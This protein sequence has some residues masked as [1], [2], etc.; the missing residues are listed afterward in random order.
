MLYQL[1][2]E[3]IVCEETIAY[4]RS[5]RGTQRDSNRALAPWWD[6]LHI[7]DANTPLEYLHGI[8]KVAK[9]YH[10]AFSKHSLD[11]G[12]TNLVQHRINTGDHLPI[13]EKHRPIPPANYQQVKKLLKEMKDSNVIQESQSP[14]A[15][16]IVLVKKKDGNIRFCVDYRKINT[17]THKDAYPL[18]RIEESIAALGSAAYFSTLDLTSGYWQVPMAPED[19]EKTA[20]TTPMGLFEFTSMPFGLCN[21]PATFQRLMERCLGHLNFQSV[22]LYLDDVIV[23]SRTYEDHV[24]HLAEVFQVLIDHGLK[25]KPSKCH[26]LKPQVNYLG[27]VVSA[28]GIQPDPE[29]ISAVEHWDTPKTVKE[30]RSF[31]GFAGYYRRFIPHFAQVA[32]PLNELLR[33]CPRESY[34]RRLPV[35]W[36]ERQEIA[37]Q[38]LKR[39]LTTPPILAYPDYNLPFRLYTDASFQGLGAVLSQVQDGQERVV[40]YASRSLRGAEKNDNNYSSFKLELLALVWAVTEKFKDYLAATPVTIYTDNNPLA[41]LNTARLGALE[42]RWAS[43]LANFQFEIKYRSGKANVNADLLSRLPKGE[44]APEDSDWEDVEMP[45][46]YQRFATQSAIDAARPET[47]SPPPRAP[48]DLARWQTIQEESRILGEIYDYLSTGRVPMRIKRPYPDVELRRL[49]RQRK[50]LF[51]QKGL[52]LRNSLDPVSGERCHQILIPRRDA[53]MVL[54]AYHDRSG[55]FGVHKTEATIRQ[56]FYWIGMRADIE[57]WCAECP[58]CNISKAGGREVRAPL[59]PITSHRPNQ[60]VALDHVKLAPTRC[61]YTYALTMV[62][63]YSKWVVVVPVRD[64][65]AKTTALT[66]YKE[67]VKHYGCPESLLTDRGPAFESQLFQ[68]LCAYHECKKLRTTAYHPQGNGLC[69]KVNQVFIN[70]LRTASVTKRVEWPHL[71]DELVEIYNN[72][73]HCSTGYSPFYLMFGRQGQLPQ[74]RALGVQAPDTFNP[75]P[76]TDWVR[77]HQR[78]IQDAREIVDRRMGEAQQRQE[79]AYN[80]RANATPLQVG[81]KVW[82]KKYH[83]SHKLESLWEPEPYVI[84]SIPYPETDVY[85]VKKPGLAPQTV[86]RNRIKRCTKE[87]LQG[88]T[89]PCPVP[90]ST[91]PAPPAAPAK[92]LSLEEMFQVEPFLMAIGYPAIPV[93]IPVAPPLPI[94]P[95]TTPALQPD[96]GRDLPPVPAPITVEEDPPLRRSERSTRGIPPLRYR[97]A[98]FNSIQMNTKCSFLSANRLTKMTSSVGRMEMDMATEGAT[99]SVSGMQPMIPVGALLS[100]LPKFNGSSVLL[101]DWRE[102]LEGAARLCNI[103]PHLR[104]ELALNTL[105]GE[106]RKTVLLQPARLRQTFEQISSILED[107]YGD[108]TSEA[109]LRKK[110]FTRYQ[111][112]DESL[113]HYANSLQELMATLQRKEGRGA[114]SFTNAEVVLRDQFL[115]GLRSQPLRRTLRERFKLEPHSTLHEVLKEAITLE[116]EEQGTIV[117]IAQ[118]AEVLPVKEKSMEARVSSLEEVI[119]ELKEALT[120]T[121]ERAAPQTHYRGESC[122][123]SRQSYREA[124]PARRCWTYTGSQVT[125]MAR[126]VFETYFPSSLH[127][128]S[129]EWVNLKA[130]NSLPIPIVGVMQVDIELWGRFMKKKGVVVVQSAMDPEVPVILGMNVLKEL[131]GLMAQELGPKYWKNVPNLKPPQVA[132]QRSLKQCRMQAT[133]S[134]LVG[135][136]GCVRVPCSTSLEVPAGHEVVVPLPVGTSHQ[137]LG[138]T[139]MVEPVLQKEGVAVGRTLCTVQSGQVLMRIMN[140]NS[141]SVVL[142]PRELV[143]DVFPIEEVEAIQEPSWHIK[144]TDMATTTLTLCQVRTEAVRTTGGQLLNEVHLEGAE[145]TPEEREKLVRVLGS[146]PNA[147]SRHEADFGKTQ[148]L[149]HEIPIGDARPVRERYRQIP[150]A[151]Y[152]EVKALLKHMQ[153]SHIIQPSRSPWASP[154]V[155]VKKKDGTLRFCV[156]YRRLNA[157]TVRDAYPL[158]RIEESL[159]ALGRAKF[160]STLDLASG[161]WQVPMAEKDR[162]KTAFVTPMGL[163]EFLRMPFGLNNAPATFQR[164]MEL[165]LGDL[166]FE[167]LLIYLDD[168]IIFSSSFAEHLERLDV[169]LGRL[170]EHGLKLKPTKCHLF[171]KSIEYLG[172]VVTRQGVQPIDSKIQAVKQWPTPSNSSELRAFLGLVGYYRRFIKEFAQV[173]APLYALLQGCLPGDTKGKPFVWAEEAELAFRELKKLLTSAPILAY[174]DFT[175]PFVLQTDGSLRGLGAVLTQEQDGQERVIAYASRTLR[176]SEKNPDNYSSFKLELLAVVWAVTEKFADILTGVEFVLMTDNNPLV[177]LNNAKLG[178]LEQR[179]AARLSKFNFKTQ[180]RPG[181]SNANA[182]ALSRNPLENPSGPTDEEREEVETPNFMKVPKPLKSAPVQGV[183][184]AVEITAGRSME[185][186]QDCQ[187]Q[188]PQIARVREWLLTDHQPAYRECET[189]TSFGKKLWLQRGRLTFREGV[190]CRRVQ[191]PTEIGPTWQ[192]VIPDS[193]VRNVAEWMHERKGHFGPAKTWAWLQRF[194]YHPNSQKVAQDICR[195]CRNCN[196]ARAGDQ[197]APIGVIQTSY[198]LQLVMM[199][200]LTVGE[201]PRGYKYLLVMVDHFTKFAVAVPTRDQTAESAAQCLWKNFILPYGCP[202]QLHSDQGACFEGRVIEEL[203]RLYQIR[204][205]RTTPYHPQGNGACE[206][207]NRTLLQLLRTL[208]EQKKERWPDYIAELVWVYNNTLHSATGYSPFLLMFG[209]NGRCP[210]T[211]MM[212]DSGEGEGWTPETWMGDHRKKVQEMYDLVAQRLGP[213]TLPANKKLKELPLQVGDRVMVRNRTARRAGK[214]Q[215]RWEVTPYEVIRQPNPTIPVYEVRPEGATGPMRIVHRNMLRPCTFLRRVPEPQPESINMPTVPS[216]EEEW[217]VPPHPDPTPLERREDMQQEENNAPSV[218]PSVELRHSGRANFGR[219]PARYEDYVLVQGSLLKQEELTLVGQSYRVRSTYPTA[220]HKTTGKPR[221]SATPS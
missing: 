48:Q 50:R 11:F 95:P 13:K 100:H 193:E 202:T 146:H 211:M 15:A 124:Q 133:L 182:D 113:P 37:F 102:R 192:V 70:M 153:E 3:D 126:K 221:K 152:Q 161:Y 65:T 62:D 90:A 158:P 55:H 94:V 91:P 150:P 219:M 112:E 49:W 173:A 184:Q 135:K 118:Q 78:R 57:N 67:Y 31:L 187:Q 125:T 175:K 138:A 28:E 143:A 20:F 183:E 199:D 39:L 156:D 186:W 85:E 151:L 168:I 198:P 200:Y 89:A 111:G 108:T 134:C 154:I 139:V 51:L 136:V 44:E 203:C 22:L 56:R 116:K 26:L 8:L 30:V 107:V 195:S 5:I 137:L 176:E 92:P 79:D 54:D 53:K 142:A 96:T 145:M 174:A 209:R 130:A 24:H 114:T 81:D 170:E 110:F 99:S 127:Q 88:L 144:S 204:K 23:Y 188:D 167:C 14:W 104:A 163:Y 159:A 213:R 115:L 68:E 33:G 210:L 74:D 86:H 140:I 9:R 34:N 66:F 6:E 84:S 69:E 162:E 101:E 103:A 208:E 17:I 52:I 58:A 177:H 75:L 18:P 47:P 109:M 155:L 191:L 123:A 201:S 59:H 60:L 71:L 216:G 220:Q 131:D 197:Q 148:T 43:R 121:V 87:D 117:T 185:E 25:I 166:N 27:H 19:R 2:P 41:H 218:E 149:E 7:G 120:I 190:L 180:Y 105:E 77:E 10:E 61:G 217:W 157:C 178:A 132:L 36:S 12:K 181:R 147:F 189:L 165:C 46:F 206:R 169:V 164:L 93:H 212:P 172:H 141:H 97:D 82:L 1:D 98:F 207:L 128:G 64:L 45:P 42:Q 122:P 32:E 16:P 63:H 83:R 119:R 73:T 215:W 196:L 29:K 72:T 21:A 214:L 179:W 171:Q 205:T 160:F 80:Q 35:E 38:T 129:T 194:F 76:E 40:A 106:A 4:Q